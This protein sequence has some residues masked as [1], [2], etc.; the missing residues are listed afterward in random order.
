MV[1]PLALWLAGQWTRQVKWTEGRVETQSDTVRDSSSLH[2]LNTRWCKQGHPENHQRHW[3]RGQVYVWI[4]SFSAARQP[5]W[6]LKKWWGSA[7]GLWHESGWRESTPLADV[8]S[9]GGWG[10][11]WK[12]V[13]VP[14]CYCEL[15]CQ[16]P[17][18]G[19]EQEE[20]IC[21]SVS[22]PQPEG[23][24]LCWQQGEG[25]TKLQTSAKHLK[26]ALGVGPQTSFS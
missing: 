15:W 8:C 25:V 7:G 3:G 23:L 22:P 5:A 14:Q 16:C 6:R 24:R 26:W 4:K 19:G 10:C 13:C 11:V 21:G 12:N 1:A 20:K 9:W 18:P 2:D 17:L